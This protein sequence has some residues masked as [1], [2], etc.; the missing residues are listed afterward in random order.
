MNKDMREVGE[1]ARWIGIICS[2]REETV[3]K[4]ILVQSELGMFTTL[5]C[6]LF[7]CIVWRESSRK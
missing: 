6:V 2:G 1:R 5:E 7:L 4:K 3:S